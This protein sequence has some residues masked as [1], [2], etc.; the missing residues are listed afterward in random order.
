VSWIVDGNN[1]LGR[2]GIARE[3][4]DA[5]RELV[6]RLAQFARAKRTRVICAFDGP[7]PPAFGKS[8]GS[9]TVVFSGARKADE[10]I[11]ERIQQ[12]GDW[13]IVTSDQGLAAR[14]RGRRVAVVPVAQF[15]RELEQKSEPEAGA[16][17]DWQA[18]FSDPKNRNIF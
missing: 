8:L 12:H 4:V 17:D 1:L 3:S 14:V 9:V 6:R 18:Y 2:L 15:A 5:K 7:E 11:A 10:V 13:M 16:A